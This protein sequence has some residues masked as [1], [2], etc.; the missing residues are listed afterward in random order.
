MQGTQLV[1]HYEKLFRDPLF[2]RF[3]GDSGYANYGYWDAST[4]T[5]KDACDRLIDRLVD[6]V[7]SPPQAML[8][9]AC[10]EGGTTHRLQ[11]RFPEARLVAVNLSPGQLRAARARVPEACFAQADAAHLPA[12]AGSFDV[13]LCVEA[14]FH[15]E[16]RESFLREAHRVLRPGGWLLM[17]DVTGRHGAGRVSHQ[18]RIVDPAAY[19][20]LLQ[21]VGF[22]EPEVVD[23]TSQTWTEFRRRYA[24]F[25]RGP[26]L[27][28][29]L[30]IV[31]R[32]PWLM[33]RSWISNRAIDAYVTV[34]A[35][36][37][38]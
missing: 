22:A 38:S 17:T 8:D 11:E 31:H 29:T 28:T 14:A 15:F 21:Q 16:S 23:V 4:K 25:A 5:G 32:L 27:L 18:N 1:E 3:L 12:L 13:V 30:R 20:A 37:R 7:E 6:A 36:R 10:G 24:R 26:G 35:Q 19:C 33:W 2:R 9:V 34:V